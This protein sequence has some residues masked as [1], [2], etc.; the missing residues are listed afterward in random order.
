MPILYKTDTC[1]TIA[2]KVIGTTQDQRQSI[3]LELYNHPENC[4]EMSIQENIISVLLEINNN[5]YKFILGT[6]N[7]KYMSYLQG[8]T[9]IKQWKIT[10][11]GLLDEKYRG[12]CGNMGL[13]IVI[14]Y[15]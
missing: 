14:Y 8:K 7:E 12:K 11:S 1:G 13:N 6:I 4:I 15:E 5:P 3:L 2:T 10:G 9:K